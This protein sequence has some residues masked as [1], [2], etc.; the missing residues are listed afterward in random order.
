MRI[1]SK[2]EILHF[3]SEKDTQENFKLIPHMYLY[4]NQKYILFKNLSK[5]HLTSFEP[6]KRIKWIEKLNQCKKA[7]SAKFCNSFVTFV[8]KL[9]QYNQS[10]SHYTFTSV[11]QKSYTN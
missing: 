8:T 3:K 6:L 9:W 5:S 11:S 4:N 7:E 2:F 10:I 1:N